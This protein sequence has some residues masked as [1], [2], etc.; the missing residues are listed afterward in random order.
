MLYRKELESMS[1]ELI[2]KILSIE[3]IDDYYEISDTPLLLYNK[4]HRTNVDLIRL[5]E[6]LLKI[7]EL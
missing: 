6:N 4:C 2:T 3:V 1:Q 7:N 5:N